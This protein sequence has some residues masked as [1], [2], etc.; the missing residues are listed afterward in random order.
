MRPPRVTM[1]SGAKSSLPGLP[2]ASAS[3]TSPRAA[4]MAVMRIGTSLSIDPCTI[5]V[6][7]GTSSS[8]IMWL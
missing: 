1:A 3:G 4:E 8:F 5:A 2:D 6:P 7:K